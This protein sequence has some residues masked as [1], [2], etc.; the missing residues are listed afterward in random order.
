[1]NDNSIIG[2]LLNKNLIIG[3]VSIGASIGLALLLERAKSKG[4]KNDD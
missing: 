2:I 4:S 3:I 1:M